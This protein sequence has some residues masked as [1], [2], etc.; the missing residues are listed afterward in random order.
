[1]L[2]LSQIEPR[3][4]IS[5]APYTIT[6]SGSYYLTTNVSVATGTAIHI[7]ASGVTLDLSGFTIS[8]TASSAVNSAILLASAI[9]DVAIFNGHILSGVTYSGGSFTGSGFAWGITGN[10]GS[11]P[12]NTRVT[13]VTVHGVSTDAIYLDP[14]A[15]YG[16]VVEH[17][18]VYTAGGH[19]IVADTVD[20]SVAYDCGTY[21]IYANTVLNC[22]ASVVGSASADAIYAVAT[23][24][25]CSGVCSN[26][27]G[28]GVYACAAQN[29]YG[30]NNGSGY[31]VNVTENAINCYGYSVSGFGLNAFTAENC[32]GVSSNGNGLAVNDTAVGCYGQS[33][34]GAGLYCV[35]A[36]LSCSGVSSNGVGLWSNYTA[37]NCYGVSQNN[38]GVYCDG[39]AVNCYGISNGASNCFGLYAGVAQNCYGYGSAGG[40]GLHCV[41]TIIGCFGYSASGYGVYVA[42]IANS[43]YG[44]SGSSTGLFANVANSCA[45]SGTPN[46]VVL[47]KYNMP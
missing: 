19:G 16:S 44:W 27:S 11:P 29:C 8:S 26:N 2:T 33:G 42:E 5:S 14:G 28:V 13:D 39:T 18:T 35:V 38:T 9:S 20:D 45:G 15:G 21:G 25:N 32:Y 34:A 30:V 41:Y 10:S 47:N 12:F 40:D 37:N 6:A 1:M 31:G 3:I 4:P 7:N 36:A 24:E 23:T 22:S 17:C 43:C 46:Y